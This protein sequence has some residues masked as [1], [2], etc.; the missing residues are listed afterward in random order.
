MND[1]E[2]DVLSLERSLGGKV[3]APCRTRVDGQSSSRAWQES[4]T[5]SQSGTGGEQLSSG[6]EN[7]VVGIDVTGVDPRS[8]DQTLGF[9]PALSTVLAS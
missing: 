4:T 3:R 9:T 5:E 1:Q 2:L 7:H 8:T 6:D